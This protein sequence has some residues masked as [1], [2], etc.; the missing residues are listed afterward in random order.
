MEA[1]PLGYW[2]DS[3]NPD[4]LVSVAYEAEHSDL[5]SV[6]VWNK[7]PEDGSSAYEAIDLR[8]YKATEG[9]LLSRSDMRYVTI[10]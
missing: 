1:A 6:E 10:K 2:V 3:G 4:E 8:P 9:K 7:Q 5:Y